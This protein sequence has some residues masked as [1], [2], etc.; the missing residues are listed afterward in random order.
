[1][2]KNITF[3]KKRPFSL[4]EAFLNEKAAFLFHFKRGN[5]KK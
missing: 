3:K 2:T 5:S 1:M 4:S